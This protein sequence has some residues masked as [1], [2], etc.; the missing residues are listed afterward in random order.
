MT[1]YFQYVHNLSWGNKF[2]QFGSNIRETVISLLIK[3]IDDYNALERCILNES[4]E[5]VLSYITG[6]VN[7]KKHYRNTILSTHTSS[8]ID[9]VDFNSVSSIINLSK[10]NSTQRINKLFRSVNTLLPKF[11][12][13][14][15]K[16]ETYGDRKINFLKRFGRTKGQVVWFVDFIINRIIP[17][18]KY[19]DR[20]YYGLTNGRRH[21][22]STSELLGRLVYC[23]FCIVD[24]RSID[25]ISYFVAKKVSS[26]MTKL[27][28]SYYPIIS[29]PRVG[30]NGCLMKVWKIRTMHPYSEYIQDYVIR[31]N[32][33]N[34]AGKPANDFRITRSGNLLRKLWIDEFPQLLQVFRGEMKLVGVRPLSATR[35][36]EF[37][38][39]LKAE[40]IRLKPGCIAPYVALNMPGDKESIEADRIYIEKYKQHPVLTDITYFFK[41][42]C[43]ILVNRVKH[44]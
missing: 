4:S 30:R 10:I 2:E 8:Y 16:I 37:P 22:M 36:N 33:Y 15:G 1:D 31:R 11:G 24:I 25:G 44:N 32:G 5:E 27:Q 38:D 39:D 7:L 17:R 29:L 42:V 14:I 6:F 3:E 9:N 19:I 40:R 43:N 23:G 35:Y 34:E 21:C 28:S 18:L 13:Y 41:G 20:I 26:P 12:V